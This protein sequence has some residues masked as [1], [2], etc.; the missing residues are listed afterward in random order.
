MYIWPNVMSNNKD[1]NTLSKGTSISEL[2]TTLGALILSSTG[3]KYYKGYGLKIVPKEPYALVILS[4]GKA[5]EN[6]VVELVELDYPEDGKVFQ[7]IPW[8]TLFMD[9]EIRFLK[10]ATDNTSQQAAIRFKNSLSLTERN[11]DLFQIMGIS[12]PI[13][14]QDLSA[15]FRS[16]IEPRTSIKFS[17]YA[18]VS[19]PYTLEDDNINEIEQ[20]TVGVE[21]INQNLDTTDINVVIDKP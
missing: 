11:F 18:N 6:Q 15:V 17:F 12:G 16:D 3:R 19:L 2:Y 13:Q 10:S 8:G 14:F 9:C 7:E 1:Y 20:Q 21:H 5:V 4:S